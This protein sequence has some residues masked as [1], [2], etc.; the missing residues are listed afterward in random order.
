V[1]RAGDRVTNPLLAR[2]LRRLA[3]EG[4]ASFYKGAFA[5]EIDKDMAAHGGFLRRTSLPPTKHC[6]PSSSR[7]RIAG[8]SSR[9]TSA[10]QLD[11]P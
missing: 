5:A 10:R 3:T 8:I 2:T 1:W 11:T 4:V 6:P 9:R 7:A